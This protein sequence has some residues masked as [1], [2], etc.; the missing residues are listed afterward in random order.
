M[1]ED[2]HGPESRFIF[3]AVDLNYDSV[4]IIQAKLII[5]AVRPFFDLIQF[6]LCIAPIDERKEREN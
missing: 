5:L 1:D 6:C 4:I 2:F 3:Y